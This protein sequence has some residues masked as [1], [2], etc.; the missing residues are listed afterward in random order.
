VTIGL[1]SRELDWARAEGCAFAAFSVY[2]L[3]QAQAV[4]RAGAEEAFPIF[5]QAGSS[6][7]GYSGYEPLVALA[8]AVARTSAGQIGVHLDHSRDLEEIRRCLEAGYT[9]VMFD[10][11][12][13]PLEENVALT[14]QVVAEA[15]AAGAWVEAELAGIPG[16]E[17]RSGDVDSGL[18]TDPDVAEVFVRTTGVDA[19]AVAIGNVHGVP[20]QPVALDLELLAAIRS[21]VSVP[22]VLHG[23]SGLDDA[24]VLNAIQLGV[25]KINVNTELRHAFR[26]GLEQQR[27]DDDMDSLL[28]PARE[29]VQIVATRK[30]ELYRRGAVIG[31]GPLRVAGEPV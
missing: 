19:L 27:P 26:N 24:Q 6:A 2:N 17:D 28:G 25:A 8:L 4:S 31:P 15:H 9:S 13:L 14:Q 10:G 11:S 5:I 16:D 18:L 21:T 22:L 7:F 12:A 30:I 1:A 20:R 23:A 29:A 3:E